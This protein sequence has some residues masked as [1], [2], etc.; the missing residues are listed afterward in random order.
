M[1]MLDRAHGE[2]ESGGNAER[3][4]F[5]ERLADAEVFLLLARESG[6][7]SIEPEVFPLEDGP[8]VLAFDTEERLS[9]FRPGAAYAA[10]TGRALARMLA[11]QGLGV[12]LN[13]GV[14]PSSFLMDAD[15]VDWLA[16]TLEGAPEAADARL[17]EVAAP[18]GLPEVLVTALDAKLAGLQGLASHAWLASVRYEGNQSGHVLAF[19]DPIPGAESALSC[20][21]REALVFSGIDAGSLD[22]TFVGATDVLAKRLAKVALR[23]DL[24]TRP[25]TEAPDAPGTDPARPP[26]LR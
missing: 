17:Q 20:A 7:D 18:R 26:K 11:G 8:V 4:R 25:D 14:A 6:G 22:V 10:L 12:G 3:L 13:L 9:E 1:T 5:Y 21:V 24:P 15:A 16:G 23:F 19:S 2:M